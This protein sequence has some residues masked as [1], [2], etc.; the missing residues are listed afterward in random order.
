MRILRRC[1]Y[2]IAGLAPNL[3][4][5]TMLLLWLLIYVVVLICK[6]FWIFRM[7]GYALPFPICYVLDLLLDLSA[8]QNSKLAQATMEGKERRT[9]IDSVRKEFAEQISRLKQSYS[10]CTHSVCVRN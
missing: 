9:A 10:V 2:S 8:Q 7:L 3:V 1:S 5:R 6:D 4:C